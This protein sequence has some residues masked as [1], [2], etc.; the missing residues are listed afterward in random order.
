MHTVLRNWLGRDNIWFG[1][2]PYTGIGHCLGPKG[3]GV[4]PEERR[5][6]GPGP[7]D[8]EQ[9]KQYSPSEEGGNM[10]QEE[11]GRKSQA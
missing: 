6:E 1:S 2:V 7:P 4:S 3:N 9:D 8:G 10:E 11:E 5:D